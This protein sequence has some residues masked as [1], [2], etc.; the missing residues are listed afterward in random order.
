MTEIERILG[1]DPNRI[2]PWGHSFL[3]IAHGYL[4]KTCREAKQLKEKL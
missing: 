1:L 3:C 4:C 2:N